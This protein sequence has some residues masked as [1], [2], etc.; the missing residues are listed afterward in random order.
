MTTDPEVY[1]QCSHC[2]RTYEWSSRRIV[3]DNSN[4]EIE[5]R[6]DELRYC[7]G[8]RCIEA[9]AVASGISIDRVRAIHG[10]TEDEAGDRIAK[11]CVTEGHSFAGGDTCVRCG[12]P[13]FASAF[14]S[15]RP[16]AADE[17]RG[18]VAIQVPGVVTGA[19]CLAGAPRTFARS[20]PDPDSGVAYETCATCGNHIRRHFGGPETATEEWP[21][22]RCD[23][24]PVLDFEAGP[25]T[26]RPLTS[27][28]SAP[29]EESAVRSRRLAE[30]AARGRRVHVADEAVDHPAHYG[31]DTV[32]EVIKVLRAWGLDGSF[33]LGNAVKYIARA[34][35]KD[36]A[37]LVEDLK[38]ARWYLDSKIQEIEQESRPGRGGSQESRSGRGGS[39]KP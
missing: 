22:Y 12:F 33:E 14:A 16:L 31:G 28:E 35:K 24:R 30:A 38:K 34:G 1:F 13:N 32:Y 19:S 17:T 8:P 26:G 23:P 18:E 21:A 36:A 3:S 15:D 29:R 20:N 27:T 11:I 4:P 2:H 9:D 10:L 39:E 37:K 7:N 5:V 25:S 6:S